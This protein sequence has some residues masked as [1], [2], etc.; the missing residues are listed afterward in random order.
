MD[1]G[2]CSWESPELDTT[3]RLTH[4][5]CFWASQVALVVK[6]TP[7][8]AGDKRDMSSISELGRS[9]RGGHGNP[10]QFSCQDNPMDRG[11]WQAMV[12]GVSKS[13]T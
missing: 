9:S 11:A 3:E 13:W 6:N 8:S 5:R 2:A 1:R 4:T 12:H 7:A 10:L